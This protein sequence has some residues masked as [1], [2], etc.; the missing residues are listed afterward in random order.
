MTLVYEV[1][2]EDVAELDDVQLTRLL[3]MLLHRNYSPPLR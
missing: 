3:K 2:A 1:Q